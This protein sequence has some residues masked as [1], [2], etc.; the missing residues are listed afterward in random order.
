MSYN[1]NFSAKEAS[2]E[3][4]C[5]QVEIVNNEYEPHYPN[6][7][8][9]YYRYLIGVKYNI[10]ES[11]NKLIL[12]IQ[13]CI[14]LYIHRVEVPLQNRESFRERCLH[15]CLILN[16]IPHSWNFITKLTL[17]FLPSLLLFQYYFHYNKPKS[18]IT[19]IKSQ[20]LASF[21]MILC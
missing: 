14:Y 3:M 9:F 13:C 15:K 10:F 12:L 7:A 11:N 6:K 18:K 2:T 1:G 19:I 4:K 20:I 17:S 5:A 16:F 21:S 8:N